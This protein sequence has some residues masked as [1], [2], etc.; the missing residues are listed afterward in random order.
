MS[1]GSAHRGLSAWII[2]R[3][4]SIYLA[5]YM[6]YVGIHLAISPPAGY[7]AW[8]AWTSGGG[9]R[10]ATALFAVALLAHVWVGLRSIWMDYLWRASVRMVVS[11]LSAVA[12]VWL[13]A[14]AFEIIFWGMRP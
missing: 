7:A 9:V 10:A 11:L 13:A 14:W 5:A 6:L 3:V 4:S 12:M 8:K 1:L 2:Q